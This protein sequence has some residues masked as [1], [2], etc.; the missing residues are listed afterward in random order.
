MRL[1]LSLVPLA[2]LVAVAAIVFRG[3]ASRPVE[4]FRL[5]GGPTDRLASWSGWVEAA[6][7]GS[8]RRGGSFDVEA[9]STRGARAEQHIELDA[10]GRAPL[11]LDFGREPPGAIQ[12][13]V[14]AEGRLLAH[15]TLALAADHWRN[16]AARRGGYFSAH[17]PGE[18]SLS[19]APGRG[20]F[21]VPFAAP[22]WIHVERGAAPAADVELTLEA[23]GASVTP[24]QLR[25]DAR[26]FAQAR[27]T[28][29]E[30][31][32]TVAVHARA[33]AATGEL[34][35][36]IP[37]VPGAMFVELEAGQLRVRSPI[38]RE[39]AF[40]TLV[41]EMGSLQTARV[42]LSPSSDGS[43]SGVLSVAEP[44]SP[45]AWAVVSGEPSGS[46][47]ALVGWPVV[48]DETPPR[49]FDVANRVLFDSAPT[50][51]AEERA[52]RRRVRAIALWVALAGALL[53]VFDLMSRARAKQ[54]ALEAH[55]AGELGAERSRELAPR[56]N[57][58]SLL[59]AG[60]ILIGFLGAAALVGYRLW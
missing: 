39:A 58:R 54:T 33:E 45:S 51:L 48:V 34:S 14:R 49:T 23:E 31:V 36:S 11:R 56:A 7:D 15:G 29:R 19:I 26:G 4:S 57:S 35:A 41:S 10:E 8:A 6:V 53:S 16:G 9:V 42:A 47:S 50:A 37:V 5:V 3:G 21:A 52:R 60:L 55:L 25:S 2:T 30:H 20:A 28:P 59:V 13:R 24:R 1:P 27:L 17:S 38:Q 46:S 32:V 40:V 18:L 43:A 44:P 12:V 22:L